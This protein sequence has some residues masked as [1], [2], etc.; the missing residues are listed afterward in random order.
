MAKKRPKTEEPTFTEML[1]RLEA[2][3][4][5]LESGEMSLEDSL[6][7]YEQGVECLKACRE[8]LE[9]A[10]RK[11]DLLTGIDDQGNAVTTRFD[12][13]EDDFDEE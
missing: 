1:E 4:D 13:A 12:D 8:K 11:I 10:Q 7:Q 5:A 2:I 9:T 6:K 3:V